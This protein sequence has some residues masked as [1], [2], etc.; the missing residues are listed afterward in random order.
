MLFALFSSPV[1]FDRKRSDVGPSH[2]MSNR[3]VFLLAHV[4]PRKKEKKVGRI[5]VGEWFLPSSSADCDRS[6]GRYLR[7]LAQKYITSSESAFAFALLGTYVT[8]H[9][10][11]LSC[12]TESVIAGPFCVIYWSKDELKSF[13]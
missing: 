2:L 7:A 3:P 8:S 13:W 10:R 11:E 5:P 1:L 12:S 6:T 4:S 9:R